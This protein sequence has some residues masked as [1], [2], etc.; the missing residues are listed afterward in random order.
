[1]T[2]SRQALLL[3]MIAQPARPY[4][5][6][7]LRSQPFATVPPIA[8]PSE[9][10]LPEGPF[11]PSRAMVGYLDGSPVL[12]GLHFEPE[13][14]LT[15]AESAGAGFHT[16]LG[17]LWRE[18]PDPEARLNLLVSGTPLQLA[19]WHALVAIPPGETRSYA[20]VAQTAGF[21]R[22]IRAAA[23]AVGSNPVSWLIPCHRVIRTDGTLGGYH[24]G[25]DMKR[26]MLALECSGL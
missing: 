24:W 21:P 15:L 18:R 26:A 3:E 9:W 5:W 1:M 20:Q 6:R 4:C 8:E 16:L 23:S 12:C 17:N 13:S 22:A 19:V 14:S 25:L 10:R 2:T 11:G 7:P